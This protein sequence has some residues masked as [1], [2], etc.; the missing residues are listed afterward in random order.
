MHNERHLY[1]YKPSS[2]TLTA[3]TTNVT[4]CYGGSNGSINTTV[5]GGTSPYTYAWSSGSTVA[6][7]VSLTAGTYSVTATDA[8][9]CTIGGSYTIT[10]P[11]AI[12]I[13]A[14]ITN[15]S[16]YGGCNGGISASATSGFSPYSYSWSNGSAISH[17][18]G[19][20]AGT[21]TV[22][23]T[24]AHGCTNTASFTVDQ[25][26]ALAI[27]AVTANVTCHGGSNGNINTTVTGGTTAYSYV[28][29]NGSHAADP[30]DLAAGTYS[31]TA[32][33]A[34]GCTITGSYTV[35][36]PATAVTGTLTVTPVYPVPTYGAAYTIYLGY[37]AQT[38]TLSESASGGV[39]GYSYSW[40]PWA[41]V[42]QSRFTNQYNN[43]QC[44]SY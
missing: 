23:V 36:Q 7:P 27:S 21:Y 42:H 14:T 11:A 16:C 30:T 17:P 2:L 10:Q 26:A 29:S 25:P 1:S 44:N 39:S 41:A 5:G 22:T 37:G 28:W 8:H 38:V 4:G 24:D 9:G 18:T 31:V 12:S 32:T 13:T 33:D 43:L 15:T 20:A 3:T 40:S 19:L 34:H 35:T 6:D